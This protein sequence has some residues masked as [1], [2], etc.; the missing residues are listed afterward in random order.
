MLICAAHW[1]MLVPAVV[2]PDTA[3]I[4]RTMDTIFL[5]LPSSQEW[6]SYIDI[7]PRRLNTVVRSGLAI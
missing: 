3:Q 4:A 1:R 7:R 5:M 6:F 2:H